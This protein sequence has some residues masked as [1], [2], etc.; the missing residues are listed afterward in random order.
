M[1]VHFFDFSC[2]EL[3]NLNFV[4]GGP[5][6]L[7]FFFI[8]FFFPFLWGC[9]VF[10]LCVC[11]VFWCVFFSLFFVFISKDDDKEG[12]LWRTKLLRILKNWSE[13]EMDY[14]QWPHRSN[15]Q[16]FNVQQSLLCPVNCLNTNRKQC[17]FNNKN[18]ISFMS[19][20]GLHDDCLIL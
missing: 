14:W 6:F 1:G 10:L 4:V 17:K 2:F 7:F 3:A 9:F 5:K 19:H 15:P 16:L 13:I 12:D 20:C 8:F 18:K 11:H